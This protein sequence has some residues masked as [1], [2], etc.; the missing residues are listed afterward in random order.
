MKI[1]K[2]QDLVVKLHI[3]FIKDG[4]QK[5][6]LFC[7]AAYAIDKLT[8][9]QE[10]DVITSVKQIRRHRPEFTVSVA[11]CRCLYELMALYVEQRG[12]LR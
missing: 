6:G 12:R 8:H 3:V 2:L 7:C 10:V 11:Q 5:C 4:V 9:E 1:Y